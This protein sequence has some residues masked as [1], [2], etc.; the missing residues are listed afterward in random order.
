MVVALNLITSP[1]LTKALSNLGIVTTLIGHHPL[2][3]GNF[4]SSAMRTSIGVRAALWIG[5]ITVNVFTCFLAFL[6]LDITNRLDLHVVRIGSR[7]R[8]LA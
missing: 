3:R 6:Y 4:P 2:A 8:S 5:G 1:K 7:S